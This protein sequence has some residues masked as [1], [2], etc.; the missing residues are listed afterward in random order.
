[1]KIT[2]GL[3]SSSQIQLVGFQMLSYATYHCVTYDVLSR[4]T[5]QPFHPKLKA[6]LGIKKG[7]VVKTIEPPSPPPPERSE[8]PPTTTSKKRKRKPATLGEGRKRKQTPKKNMTVN[9]NMNF[10]SGGVVYPAQPQ[11]LQNPHLQVRL[12]A[13]FFLR[14]FIKGC[15]FSGLSEEARGTI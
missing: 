8:T 5:L 10:L 13:G 1:M 4:L 6:K 3:F 11:Q 9:R 14:A 7:L 15:Y 2:L 12:D